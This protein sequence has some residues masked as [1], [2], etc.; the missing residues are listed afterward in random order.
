MMMVI[1]RLGK[2]WKKVLKDLREKEGEIED[3]AALNQTLIIK[4]HK[5]YNEL[6]D[7]RKELTNVRISEFI[8]LT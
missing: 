3:L 2:I 8:L 5:S 4:E 7:A 1:Q 6:Q